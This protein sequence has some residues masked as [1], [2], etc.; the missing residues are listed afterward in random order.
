MAT[1][2]PVA[3][4]GSSSA[5]APAAARRRPRCCGGVEEETAPRLAH[6]NDP[7]ATAEQ[8]SDNYITTAKYSP[9]TFVPRALFEQ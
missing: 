1:A 2:Q 7:A 8:Y 9:L 3:A 6:V 4:S 5:A